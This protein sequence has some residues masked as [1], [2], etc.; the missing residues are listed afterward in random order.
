ME[1]CE[2]HTLADLIKE[3]LFNQQDEYWRLFRQIIDALEY[4]HMNG[5]IHRDL[6]PVNIFI[7]Q[8]KNVKIGDFGLAKVLVKP[9]VLPRLWPIQPK[10]LHKK[11]VLV[12]ILP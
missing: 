9:S 4:M 2:N 7:D 8:G 6:K 11:L 10:N 3:G 12:Y 1:Y 5:I